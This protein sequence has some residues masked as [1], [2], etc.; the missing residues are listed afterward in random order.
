MRNGDGTMNYEFWFF[1][2]LALALALG[3]VVLAIFGDRMIKPVDEF[4]DE[5]SGV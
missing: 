4:N 1:C 3:F 2:A 5:D